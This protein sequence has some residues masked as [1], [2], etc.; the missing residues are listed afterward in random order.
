MVFVPF[1]PDQLRDEY[2]DEVQGF[3]LGLRE[4]RVAL[5]RDLWIGREK[6]LS[7]YGK[8]SVAHKRLLKRHAQQEERLKLITKRNRELRNEKANLARSIATL[9]QRHNLERS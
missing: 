6:A 3:V 8:L 5:W 2:E 9:R 4:A 7:D 1:P